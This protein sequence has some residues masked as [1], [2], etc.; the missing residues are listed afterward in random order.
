[1]DLKEK[2]VLYVCW[3]DL[4][5][6]KNKDYV[7]LS[8]LSPSKEAAV[9]GR[10]QLKVI[11]AREKAVNSKQE[12]IAIYLDLVGKV[13][14]V[15][16]EDGC[17]FREDLKNDFGLSRWWLH[18][19][20]L[21]YCEGDPIFNYII[22]VL[23]IDK[24]YKENNCSAIQLFKAPY[25]ITET[26]R[27]KYDVLALNSKRKKEFFDYKLRP[28]L[29]RIK[30][31]F[32]YICDVFYL[33]A[34]TNNKVKADLYFSSFWGVAL[35]EDKKSGRLYDKYYKAIPD[36][37]SGFGV[38]YGWLVWFDHKYDQKNK[39]LKI[40]ELVSSLKRHSNVVVAQVFLKAKDVILCFMD[41]SPFMK[42]L[43]WQKNLKFKSVFLY[44]G[45]D[46]Y[47]LFKLFFYENFLDG[48]ISC[49]ELVGLA[50]KRFAEEYKPNKVLSFLEFF[51]YAR[52]VN[53]GI[54]SGCSQSILYAM[55]H[56]SYSREKTF[57]MINADL[58]LRN[59]DDGC[60]IPRPDYFFAMGEL[61]KELFVE[62]GF[63]PDEIFL[64][65]SA[66]YDKTAIMEIDE[67]K[68]DFKAKNILIAASLDIEKEIDMI[69][70]VFEVFRNIDCVNI[71]VR[72]HPLSDVTCHKKFKDF[73]GRVLVSKGTTLELDLDEA[74]VVIFSYSTVGEEAYVMGIPAWHWVSYEYDAS[75]FR[76]VGLVDS[77]Y[78][79]DSLKCLY[80]SFVSD[81]GKHIPSVEN[82]KIVKK[83]CFTCSDKL[84][85]ELIAEKLAL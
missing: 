54:K 83:K 45:Y 47:P 71:K 16:S 23:I 39:K 7:I 11:S 37:L 12:A 30:Y 33:K 56:A 31:C 77:F 78:D 8:F 65:G 52:A 76:D 60:Q 85:S 32:E 62:N 68:R 41:I 1:M 6:I 50:H 42:F 69:E 29:R 26:L 14:V 55:Q 28:V 27:S 79:V 63:K 5:L 73:D 13:G 19:I 20:S 75:V 15:K 21:R 74:D 44:N 2:K 80:E 59:N 70:A 3:D 38:S 9:K 17:T 4:G 61:G 36:S 82:R 58:E 51:P 72:S 67:C 84:P 25:E 35:S 46:L 40:G 49:Y 64:T 43:K 24:V 10:S 34:I 81:P 18:R 22:Q 57:G 48:S 66:R 53:K